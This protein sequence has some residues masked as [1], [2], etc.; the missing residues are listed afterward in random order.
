MGSNGHG[1][2]VPTK[3]VV[4]PIFRVRKSLSLASASSLH[5]YVELPFTYPRGNRSYHKE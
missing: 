2:V 1:N 4:L 3:P 5:E